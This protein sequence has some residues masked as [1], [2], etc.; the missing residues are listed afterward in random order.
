MIIKFV[1]AISL[2][3]LQGC[4]TTAKILSHEKEPLQVRKSIKDVDY[5]IRLEPSELK[6]RVLILPFLDKN[7]TARPQDAREQARTA[8]V[9]DLVRTTGVIVVPMAQLKTPPAKYIK[10]GEYDLKKIAQDSQKQGFTSIIEGQILDV[11]LK[12]AADQ[13]GLVRDIST[14]YEVVVRMRIVN[15]RTEN[16]VFNTVKTVTLEEDNKRIIE[17]VANDQFFVRNPELLKILIKD[18]FLDFT[19][20]IQEAL[21]DITWEGRIAAIRG[22]KIYLNV[23]KISGVLIGDILK[24]VE[25]GSEIYDPEIGY[26]LGRIRG[27]TKG[28]LEIISYFGQDGA[29]AMMHSGANFKESDRVETYKQ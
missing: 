12:N 27:R 3:G 1:L 8:F 13:I 2:L 21:V 24:V 19:P 11:K 17:R 16:E 22:E 14:I 23:G 20:Q 9:D 7:E 25:D 10:N 28:T 4:I 26:H 5:R 18:A 29:V 15:V 6:K